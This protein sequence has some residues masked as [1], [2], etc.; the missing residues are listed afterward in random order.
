[1]GLTAFFMDDKLSLGTTTVTVGPSG[2][3]PGAPV[4]SALDDRPRV[5]W[6]TPLDGY[7]SVDPGVYIDITE[8]GG[9]EL[10]IELPHM[11]GRG[12]AIAAR[13]Q[14]SLNNSSLTALTYTAIYNH[15][16]ARFEISASG[17]FSI[18][19]ASG[20]H[21]G[22]TEIRPWLGFSKDA[23]DSGGAYYQADERRYGTDHWAVFDLGSATSITLGACILAGGDDV[24]WNDAE[25]SVVKL[26]ANAS[27][28]S[29]TDRSKWVDSA[30]K[31]LSFSS[32]PTED[33]NKIQIAFDSGGAAM[34]YRYWA[35]SWRYFDSDPF[36]AVGIVKALDEY[37][38]STRQITELKG[39]GLVDTSIPL[40]VKSYYPT[41]NLMTWRAPLN[42][43]NWE[44]DDYRDV[45]TAVVREG[46]SH[47]LIWALRWN[48]IADGTYDAEDEADKGFLLWAALHRYSQDDYGGAA[49]DYIS[50]EITLEQVR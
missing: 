32:R 44:A 12:S 41:E 5:V 7:F 13:L 22:T 4:A 29:M 37:G 19:W 20:T 46:R 27:N 10:Q 6:Q 28:L 31:E 9:S 47:G 36:H 16:T 14:D 50:G 48:L 2:D 42:F 25:L 43:N 30:S 15:S 21:S 8:G 18:L 45:V 23:D 3:T 35:F 40:G 49:S 17:T 1:V 33:Q 34:G 39:H 11:A 26:F 24:Q 38:S